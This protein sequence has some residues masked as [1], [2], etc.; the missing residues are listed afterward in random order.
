MWT[1]SINQFEIWNTSNCKKNWWI[2]RYNRSIWR[3]KIDR[4]NFEKMKK[5][6]YKLRNWDEKGRVKKQRVKEIESYGALP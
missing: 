6:Y 2:K 3:H 4:K 1:C 5:R